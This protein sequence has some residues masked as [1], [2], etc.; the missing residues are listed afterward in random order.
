MFYEIVMECFLKRR[1]KIGKVIEEVMHGICLFIMKMI[2][3][4]RN[5]KTEYVSSN[6]DGVFFEKKRQNR[7]S[8]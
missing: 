1:D 6:K 3:M 7:E 8:N 5:K 2:W 4:K